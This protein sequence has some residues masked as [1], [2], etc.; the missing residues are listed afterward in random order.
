VLSLPPSPGDHHHER[1]SQ[2]TMEQMG[3]INVVIYPLKLRFGTDQTAK[4]RQKF[5]SVLVVGFFSDLKTRPQTV[6]EFAPIDIYR[7]KLAFYCQQIPPGG[8]GSWIHRVRHAPILFH[9]VV[10]T[11]CKTCSSNDH[12]SPATR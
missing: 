6:G 3:V 12:R 10:T 5:G 9:A 2:S 8:M 11:T 1:S 7:I 4:I